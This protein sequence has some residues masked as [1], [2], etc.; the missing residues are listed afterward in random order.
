MLMV[1]S[2][3]MA[4]PSFRGGAEDPE[5]ARNLPRPRPVRLE[6]FQASDTTVRSERGDFVEVTISD[7]G[8]GI[9]AD[10][11]AR[12]FER[13]YQVDK[14]RSHGRGTGLGLAIIKEII[15]AHS[16]QIR[17]E[18][19]VNEGTKF[20]VLLPVTEADAQTL[21]SARDF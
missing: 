10:N 11:L 3:G 21:I 13:F 9:P 14:S 8:A 6:H 2:A 12:V 5:S 7:T 1:S 17:A 18:S 4:A 19:K 20:V 15:D 16:G